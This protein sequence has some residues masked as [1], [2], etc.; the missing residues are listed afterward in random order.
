M[1]NEIKELADLFESG[2]ILNRLSTDFPNVKWISK[3]LYLEYVILDW[4][5]Y[6]GIIIAETENWV[7]SIGSSMF[8]EGNKLISF[9]VNSNYSFSIEKKGS[10]ELFLVHSYSDIVSVLRS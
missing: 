6:A 4:I 1:E 10:D 2:D 8:E 3:D 9:P 5:N 7:L